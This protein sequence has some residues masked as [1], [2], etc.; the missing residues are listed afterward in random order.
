ME[1]AID[2]SLNPEV[3]SP[4]KTADV[5]DEDATITATG[6]REPGRTTVLAKHSIKEEHIE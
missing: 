4:P 2:E 3:S 5:L 6:F 1:R